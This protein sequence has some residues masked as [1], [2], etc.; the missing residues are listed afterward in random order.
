MG[1]FL[2]DINTK[3]KK[4]PTDDTSMDVYSQ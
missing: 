3:E 2:K 1:F 4:E